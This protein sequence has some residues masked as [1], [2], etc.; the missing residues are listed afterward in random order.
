[1]NQKP[2]PQ[3]TRVLVYGT[4]RVDQGAYYAFDL[5][6]QTKHIGTV[7]IPGTIYDLGAFPGVR[8]DG[9]DSGV[10]CDVLEVADEA[11]VESIIERLDRYEGCRPDN[12]GNSLYTREVVEVTDIGPCFIYEINRDTAKY[13]RIESGDWLQRAT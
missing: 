10:V 12:P 7:R 4:L 5:K 9:D 6:A 1:M 11:A 8:L 2:E 13:R 3:P